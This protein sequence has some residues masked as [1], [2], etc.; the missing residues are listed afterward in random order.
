MHRA[1]WV[2]NVTP[3]SAAASHVFH[4]LVVFVCE[5]IRNPLSTA[6]E[7][8][9]RRH[10]PA[11]LPSPIPCRRRTELFRVPAAVG[12]APPTSWQLKRQSA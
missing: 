8:D 2:E 12:P 4:D 3:S 10:W 6:C 7:T 1:A 11:R 5:V 9:A